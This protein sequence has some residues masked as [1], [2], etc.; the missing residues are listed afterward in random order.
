MTD[1][2][3][4]T[5]RLTPRA[6]QLLADELIRSGAVAG[7]DRTGGEPIAIVGIG[8]RFPG[9]IR[10]PEDY[11]DLLLAGRD[12]VTETPGHRWDADEFFDPDP[13]T[14]NRTTSR[15]GGYVDDV[16][17]FDAD[18]FGIAPREAE[19]MDPQQRLLLEVT[20]E[21]LEHAGIAPDSLYG[22]ATGVIVGISSWDYTIVSLERQTD[23]DAYLTTG[24]AHSVAAGRISYLLGLQGPAY[25][26]D[27][28]CSSSL[29][30][31]HN[32]TRMLRQGEADLVVAGGVQLALS[33]YTAIALSK[34]SALS[35]TGRSRAFDSGAD[36]F[37]RGEGCGIV[38]LERLSDAY[39]NNRRILGV[40]RGSAVNH[41]GRSNGLTAPNVLAQ[42][43]VIAS[44]LADATCPPESV[45]LIE[46]HGTGTILGDPIEFEALKRTYGNG[47]DP[48]ALGAVKTNL[49][50]LEAAAGIAGLIKVLLAFRHGMIP[51][52]LH[53]QRWNPMI[54]ATGTRF[55]IPV[56]ATKWDRGDGPRRA[57]VS[58]FGLSGTN[59]HVIVEEVSAAPSG[60]SV[61]DPEPAGVPLTVTVPGRTDQRVRDSA[62]DLAD[63]IKR[64]G[65][66]WA[67][68]DIDHTL[69][70]RRGRQPRAA[71]IVGRDTG[72][73]IERLRDVADQRAHPDIRLH[74]VPAAADATVHDPVWVFSGYGSQWMGMGLGL[75]D[76]EPSFAA[77]ID[78]LAPAFASE[79][80]TDLH[81]LLREGVPDRIDRVQPVIFALQVAY[82]RLW[83]ERGF[84]P[85]A[86][87]GHSMG[88]VAAAV[89]AGA[90]E[91][92]D[93]MAVIARRSALLRRHA[94]LGAMA[95]V[96]RDA[97]SM[98]DLLTD[99]PDSRIAVYAAP[100]QCVVA[101][102]E[103][104][105]ARLL[106]TAERLN[107]VARPVKCEVASHCPLV[108]GL[109]P[110]LA[111]LLAEVQPHAPTVGYYSTSA[112]TPREP[113]KFDADYWVK[114]LREPVRLQAA[115]DAALDD[116]YRVFVELAP[117]PLLVPAIEETVRAH[118]AGATV[119]VTACSVR[120]R[121]EAMSFALGR[122]VV[123]AAGQRRTEGRLLDLHPTPW[124]HEQFRL[125]EPTGPALSADV[126]PLLGIHVE[127]PGGRHVW[128]G[129]V[130]TRSYP[131]ALDHRIFG[132]PALPG[133]AF[134]ELAYAA[135]C[136]ALDAPADRV[137][138]RSVDIDHLMML[139]DVTRIAV[140]ADVSGDTVSLGISRRE[141]GGRWVR[142]ARA[143]AERVE[144]PTVE[145]PAT[146]SPATEAEV[147]AA[148]TV[149]PDDLYAALRAVGLQHGTGFRVVSALERQGS[150]RA[151]AELTV[152][153]AASPSPHVVIDPVLLDG[154]L[155]GIAACFGP[156]DPTA[157][158]T[159]IAGGADAVLLPV[160]FRD[161][162][163]QGRP[164]R[165][166]IVWL[167]VLSDDE[168]A[169]TAEGSEA[170][171][172]R[173]RTAG[174]AV[175][176]RVRI[177]MTDLA[178][179]P[180]VSVG[181]VLLGRSERSRVPLPIDR[182][183]YRTRWEGGPPVSAP[184]DVRVGGW[185]VVGRRDD[186][187]ELIDVLREREGVVVRADLDDAAD[188]RAGFDELTAAQV[189]PCGVVLLI[190]DTDGDAAAGVETVWRVIRTVHTML[191]GWQ[192]AT[193]RLWLITSGS[194]PAGPDDG[195]TPQGGA[196][197][198][199]VRTLALEHPDL[200]A[201]LL[202]IDPS[203]FC[204]SAVA[205][206]VN[207]LLA[208]DRED[209]IAHRGGARLTA[210]LTR[211][212]PL[213]LGRDDS[214]SRAGRRPPV[215]ADGAYIVSGGMGGIGTV[216]AEWLL[217][218]GAARVVVNGRSARPEGI[219]RLRAAASARGGDVVVVTGDIAVPGT[220]ERLVSEAAGDGLALR[221]VVHAAAIVDD[222]L[223]AALTEEALR[224]IW[225]PKATG[226]RHLVDATLGAGFTP[227][228]LVGFSSIAA[229][230]GA[231]G[232]LAYAAAS[233]WLSGLLRGLRAGGLPA[234]S[235]EWG[236][237]S[238]VGLASSLTFG[239]LDPIEPSEGI[240][241]L[242]A[243][244]GDGRGVT[245]VARLR[246]D[247]AVT[248]VPELAA[249]PFVSGLA[250]ELDPGDIDRWPGPA[251][252]RRLGTAARPLIDERVAVRVAGIL[253]FGRGAVIDPETSL[254]DTGMDSLMAVRIR[255]AVRTDF[256]VELPISLLL[257]EPTIAAIAERIDGDLSGGAP[258]SG[259]P[260]DAGATPPSAADPLA[261]AA[262]MRAQ[263]R[264]A[265]TRRTEGQ[266][267]AR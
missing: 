196:L 43:A 249:M 206:V 265:A 184:T 195:G 54:D 200:R 120:D 111:D 87:I 69:A 67:S 238:D 8:C 23:V 3:A 156:V 20:W 101:G 220:A 53:F 223:A 135:A 48:C 222:G 257:G 203:A 183:M 139:D 130:G 166:A 205:G 86:V 40:L 29:V 171:G 181:A 117:H 28:A 201:T 31:V 199:V 123:A 244:L 109:L 93:A 85:G 9:G 34:W 51:S 177:R 116:G 192:G 104:E 150:G 225:E 230:L 24:N 158:I 266:S 175:T 242:G 92:A 227:D 56:R 213:G 189:P 80:G 49:G 267:H 256:D 221:G 218:E 243:V 126:H 132:E 144:G 32:A 70:L 115:V 202:D 164:G 240:A 211:D 27:T 114:N 159:E 65:G 194:V 204:E 143:R 142:H 141:T 215:R 61:T 198:A 237:W 172:A 248:L 62:R 47:L 76:S 254:R 84:T 149:V 89:V 259:E 131:A 11:W 128:N 145:A 239:V 42:R 103:A 44:A 96:Q 235:I 146:A 262:E 174:V 252:L 167:T 118:S 216:V 245:A 263:R 168:P 45:G 169:A 155:Q 188:I 98:A 241:A 160:G 60:E 30:A 219:E 217:T 110:E 247:R 78:E 191:N 90:L 186:P 258:A 10:G 224:R 161:V 264:R 25:S 121:D 55:H 39:R 5:A 253:G 250:A 214:N 154:A 182:L 83:R 261:T 63:V 157:A 15:W 138:L 75:L 19:A 233:G 108:D 18:F 152:P 209:L 105:I 208:D 234:T 125:P 97:A 163:V 229:L 64:R 122:A 255:H 129:D 74:G 71:T 165:R 187:D 72:Q 147:P 81:V 95:V 107:I 94:G 260:D 33:P 38:V 100:D 133:T 102:A 112:P 162:R 179:A 57:A 1:L 4:L 178:D 66:R 6:R 35:P 2:T 180:T 14:P 7:G 231:P 91:P 153:T 88:E 228:W 17:G 52:N 226:A 82:A 134:V 58:S 113:G 77:A 136:R 251:E 137:I 36:G 148:A 46:T 246:P 68:V 22:S 236:A 193:P 212:E 119:A 73:L 232:Q 106:D 176:R 127:L 21:A 190:R 151:R 140:E 16:D 13:T 41:D 173:G 197:Q 50:H 210:R 12:A 185:L 99:L 79:T 124:R 37:V 207:E 170:A 26:L 59:A